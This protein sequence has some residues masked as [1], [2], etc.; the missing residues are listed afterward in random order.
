MK[1]V[2]GIENITKR[3][4][5]Y[6]I[7]YKTGETAK[8]YVINSHVFRYY[9]S[10]NGEFI[11]YPIP[12]NSDDIA[13]IT[14]KDI[15]DYD[16]DSFTKSSL[17]D[18]DKYYE[19]EL[20]KVQIQ[21]DKINGT[22][23][24]YDKR[25]NKVAVKE[26][27]PLS[28]DDD[29]TVQ[30]LCQ[31]KEEYFFGGGMQNGRFTHK[32]N[33]I[34]IVNT[35]NWV[36]GGVTSP[37]PF[38]WSS[39]G[40]GVLRHTWQ[41]G[42]YDFGSESS[43]FVTTT[44]KT[45]HFD[46]FYFINSEP[47]DILSDY[48][49]LTGQPIFMPEY[50]FYEAHLNAF[51]RDYWVKTTPETPGAILFEDGNYYKSYKPN[52]MGDKKGIL[53]SLNGEKDNYQFSAR[54]MIDRYRRHDMPLGWFIPNDGYGSGYG[55]TD[56]L[57]G[58]IENLKK[59][60]DYAR[61][62]GVEVALWT[63]SNLHPA[64]P[65]H[66]KKGERDLGKELSVAKVV[67]LKC[68]VA[69]IGYGYSFGL[70]A[71]DDVTK[72]FISKTNVRPMIIMVDGWAGTQRYSGI[73]S[74][75]QTGGQWEYIRFHIPT[76]IGSGL[77][78]Q[79]L[80]G[81]DMDGIYGG[82]ERE[83]NI[84]DYQWKTFTP[85]QLNM[86]G[87]GRIPKTPF[88]FDDEAIS[89][90]RAYLKL[91]SM[92]LPYNYTIGQESIRGLPMIRAMFLE[93]PNERIAYTKD[94]QYQFMWGPHILVAPIYEEGYNRDGVYLPDKNQVWID[95]FTGEKIQGGKFIN[96]LDIPLWKIP[97]FIKDGAIIPMTKPNNN[98]NEI[99]RSTRI[100]TVYPNKD[101]N[102]NVY[103][104]DGI[105]SD[106]LKGQFATTEITVNAPAS[107]KQGDL[108]ISIEKTKGSYESMIKER[109][110]LLQIMASQD[111]EHV[112]A[113][114]NG[115]SLQISK[116]PSFDE[117][118]KSVN[119]FFFKEDFEINPYLAQFNNI[120]QAVLLIKIGN[121]DVT[122]N[123]IQIKVKDYA[124]VTKV[125]GENLNV[126]NDLA[127]PNYFEVA[128]EVTPTIITLQWSGI[129]KVYYEIEKDGI[130]YSNIKQTKFTFQD[131][132]YNTEY[133]FRIRVANEYGV[134]EWSEF[135]KVKTLDDPYKNVIKGV[136]VKCNI[137]C[138][139]CQEICNLTDG[140]LTSLWHTH[141]HKPIQKCN[142]KGD[143]KLTFDLGN[144]YHLEKFEYT[145]R[146]DAGNGTFLKIQYKYSVDGENWS[147]LTRPIILE[148][149]AS[150]KTID[151]QGI[152]LRHF[153][154]II[155]DS[156]GGF[157]SGKQIRF[158]KKI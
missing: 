132:K 98:P 59:F 11:D 20:N 103:E 113:A 49:E 118:E 12:N 141:W 119:A 117:F 60:A 85:L 24:V 28:Y 143:L 126:N 30:K 65:L 42:V 95:F 14:I 151:L 39:Y 62:K 77:S 121:L 74:G 9:M 4:E 25:T 19:I 16:K 35:N 47:C 107:N 53:E 130:I 80:I 112:K 149:N 70:N 33:I 69:W 105:T 102:F 146:D 154:L 134:S 124:N 26:S 22:M 86:D 43:D 1:I 64:D 75:D 123:H 68:D 58:D 6:L 17:K 129:D 50:A 106:Y 57:D 5:D 148:R 97:V 120:P 34:H 3:E 71:V 131:L 67:A 152:K 37:C 135:I 15:A 52:E 2:G 110:T 90:N 73:W 81:S 156:V 128:D 84:R 111:V 137:P 87:W 89:I 158:Y 136:K 18:V 40:Y 48:Y 63:E 116:A 101:S 88:S 125:L 100:F 104:D 32:G 157:G 55:Q 13:K 92:F 108:L 38:Y 109:T 91:K 46:A 51:N 96:N 82:K 45:D 83:V 78:G 155:L 23:S 99:D 138:Q 114:I 29:I 145:P 27:S 61:E 144:V 93:F 8:V 122:S 150:I 44:H 153:E 127:T 31:K 56:S 142:L 7:K 76:Y 115:Q 66:P 36:D 79:P 147:T 21:F 139:P 94:C 54:A 10:P 133:L 72:I 140:A 41:P